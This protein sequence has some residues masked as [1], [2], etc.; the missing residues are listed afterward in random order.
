MR[1]YEKEESFGYNKIIGLEYRL[2]NGAQKYVEA[3][4]SR[5]AIVEN[6]EMVLHAREQLKRKAERDIRDSMEVRQMPLGIPMVGGALGAAEL[7]GQQLQAGI[8]GLAHGQL[9]NNV[10]ANQAAL[11]ATQW[12][13]ATASTATTAYGEVDWGQL[14][15]NCTPGDWNQVQANPA[16]YYQTSAAT[17]SP[18]RIKIKFRDGKRELEI[19]KEYGV[20]IVITPEDIEQAKI[21]Y[22]KG[23]R[24]RVITRRA[25]NKAEELLKMLVSEVDF[26]NYKEKGYFTVKNGNKIYRIWKDSHKYIDCFEKSDGGVLVPRNRLCTHTLTRELPAADEAIQKLMLIRSNKVLEHSNAHGVY[27]IEPLEERELVLA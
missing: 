23:C 20:E 26:R 3:A 22:W 12:Y 19:E 21:N 6:P 8:L 15:T 17:Y 7:V 13:T 14:Q 25:E 1:F 10:M 11:Q 5:L 2:A 9:A 18:P 24:V 4:I 27:G 16:W